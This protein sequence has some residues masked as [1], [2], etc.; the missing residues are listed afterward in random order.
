MLGRVAKLQAL[1]NL[2][3][4]LRRKCFVERSF[5]VCVQI[6]A[7]QNHLFRFGITTAQQLLN[8]DGPINLGPLLAHLH[9]APTR[10]RLAEHEDACRPC[11]FVFIVHTSRMIPCRRHRNASFL[12]K[13]HRLL[14]HTN[15]RTARIVGLGIGFQHFFHAG[16]E[17]TIGLGRNHPVRDLASRHAVFLSVRRTLS[18]LTD[19]TIPNSTTFSATK[20]S[21][22]FATPF[23]AGPKRNAKT[24]AICR[25][26]HAGPSASALSR[27]CARRTLHDEP[28]SFLTTPRRVSRSESV[29]RTIYFFSMAITLL[30]C[31]S[32]RR[33]H[34]L[35]AILIS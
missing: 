11:A 14:V 33:F 28:L 30:G 3:G 27:I 4:L 19:S 23:G 16:D 32:C 29:R 22:Q 15:H 1:H 10:K 20:R 35:N 26:V 17:F 13:L 6:V 5:G 12:E 2:S 25:S 7:D 18:W 9:F 8:L 21:D 34:P 24:L 31:R